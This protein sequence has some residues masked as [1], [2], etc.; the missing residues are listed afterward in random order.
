VIVIPF[1]VLSAFLSGMHVFAPGLGIAK[2]TKHIAV[3]NIVGAL[4][5]VGLNVFLVPRFG[6][7]GAATATLISSSC[8]FGGFMIFSQRLYP[9][10]HDFGRFLGA[11][12]IVL[13]LGSVGF[14]LSGFGLILSLLTKTLVLA[15]CAACL[16]AL[17]IVSIEELRHY[18]SKLKL[19]ID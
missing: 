18:V 9:V 16:V 1:L 2:K 13:V 15:V 11:T 14:S 3:I 8:V 12:F 4:L 17:R 19:R 7:L 10:P 5:N 6:I